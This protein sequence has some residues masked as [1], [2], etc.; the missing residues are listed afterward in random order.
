MSAVASAPREPDAQ[1]DGTATVGR[2]IRYFYAAVAL[3]SLMFLPIRSPEAR[4]TILCNAGLTLAYLG[5]IAI[6]RRAVARSP[7]SLVSLVLH[8]AV[9]QPVALLLATMIDGA[10]D[11]TTAFGARSH[12]H[13]SFYVAAARLGCF[14]A[15]MIGGVIVGS[16]GSRNGRTF[17]ESLERIPPR[18][19]TTLQI[20]G[21][22]AVVLHAIQIFLPPDFAPAFQWTLRVTGR[23]LW[24]LIMFVGIGLHQGS[25]LAR[26]SLAV[27]VATGALHTI[28]GNRQW[29]IEPFVLIAIAWLALRTVTLRKLLPMALGAATF[30]LFLMFLGERF[31]ADQAGRTGDAAVQRIESLSSGKSVPTVEHSTGQEVR[32]STLLRF[33]RNATHAVITQIP[34][35]TDHEPGGLSKL[36]SDLRDD[37]LP[38]FYVEGRTR[39]HA[40]RHWFLN[41]FGFTVNWETS[42]ELCLVA[43]AWYRGGALGCIVI[44][45]LLGLSLQ[46]LER[47][48]TNGLGRR[49]ELIVALIGCASMMYFVEGRDL[50]TGIRQLA[51]FTPGFIALAL[52]ARLTESVRA[53]STDHASR[54]F[55]L[56]EDRAG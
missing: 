36:P 52:I 11:Y 34:E 37:L 48:L 49:P 20:T 7:V 41:D 30:M 32:D 25:T 22:I 26:I 15:V 46:G 21:V 55:V 53:G 42:V 45:L 13:G 54:P 33:L 44:G 23:T 29:A 40:Y 51:L 1:L 10:V 4:I 5:F 47:L 14:F 56:S 24:P 39:E 2:A 17:R 27:C 18:A 31:R 6:H 28:A 43:D 3:S 38:G 16:L 50:V 35:M 9:I 8:F 19:L 12:H